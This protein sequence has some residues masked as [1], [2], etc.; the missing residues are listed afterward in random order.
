[1][2]HKPTVEDIQLQET[3]NQW[4]GKLIHISKHEN[5]DIDETS[6]T[7]SSAKFHERPPTIDN[8]VAPY[9]LQLHGKG[10]IETDHHQYEQ[11]PNETYEIPLSNQHEMTINNEQIIIK[12]EDRSYTIK[13]H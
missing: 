9:V 10:K 13:H 7:L 12:T 6:M 4:A 8:Y 2:N 1:M 3:L 5:R 11:I